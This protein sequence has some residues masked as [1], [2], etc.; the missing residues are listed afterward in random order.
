MSKILVVAEIK[1]GT[2]RKTTL[3]LLAKAVSLGGG[4]DA[5]LAGPGAAPLAD[6]LAGHGAAAVYVADDPSLALFSQPAWLDLTAQAVETSQAHQVWFSANETARSVAPAL[7]ARLGG[8]FASN[9]KAVSLDGDHV[10]VERVAM[11][12]KVVQ[13]ARLTGKVKVLVVRGGA[14]DAASNNPKPAKTVKLTVPKPDDRVKVKQVLKEES[15]EL[16]LGDAAQV[17][18]V[19]RGIKDAQG[20]EFVRPL[21]AA[22]GAAMGATRAVVDSGWMA[23]SAQVG[24][25]G[26]T[27]SPDVY[28]AIGLSGAIQHLAGMTG[29]KLIVAVNKDPEAP[30]FSVAD[31]AIVGDLFKVV[32]LLIEEIKKAQG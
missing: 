23:H 21:A 20:V 31:Y 32:P 15:G 12:T 24:Q 16:D 7:A 14:F 1:N 4:V 9:V 25:T 22:L 11:A 29:S 18:S 19:G 28:W 13:K 3:E 2:V 10:L 27:V 26:R 5:L 30:I 8:A 17:V 6:I